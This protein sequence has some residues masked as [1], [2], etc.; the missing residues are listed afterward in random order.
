MNIKVVRDHH[1]NAQCSRGLINTHTAPQHSS[2]NRASHTCLTDWAD[3]LIIYSAFH[4]GAS[5]AISTYTELPCL[6]CWLLLLCCSIV[7]VVWR[8]QVF[9][10]YFTEKKKEHRSLS[11]YVPLCVARTMDIWYILMLVFV[12]FF[13]FNI[14]EV[15][16][17]AST[18]TVLSDDCCSS[19]FSCRWWKCCP[20]DFVV[21]G[22][23]SPS[24]L[25]LSMIVSQNW[26]GNIFTL[27]LLRR[28]RLNNLC[29]AYM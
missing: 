27:H 14:N 4:W 6:C 5:I 18:T 10:R 28:E 25:M 2:Q 24:H 8:R 26:M 22:T 29:R 23:L 13:F 20:V 16:S 15:H 12:F 21:I 17:H 1:N 11:S 19:W 9:C 3:T 7:V